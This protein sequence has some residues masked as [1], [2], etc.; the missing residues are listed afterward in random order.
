MHKQLPAMLPLLPN[1]VWR[2]YKGGMTLDQME[3]KDQP[4]DSHFPEDW[5]LST[6][7]AINK[8]REAYVDEG[9]S[10]V[11][12]D[13][14]EYL[15]TDLL[16]QEPQYFLGARHVQQF[17]SHA[18][19]LLKYL[20]SS[21]RLHIQ[22]HPTIAFSQKY[23]N[24]NA[25]KTEGYII[26]GGRENIDPYIYMG[27]QRSPDVATF[28]KAIVD[29]DT[30]TI[31]SYFDKIPVKPGDVFLVPGGI[32]HAIGEG[33]FMV[34]IMEPTDFAV[35][36]EFERG[37]YVLPEEARFM[38]RD[39][40]FAL[41]MFDFNAYDLKQ[42]Q[43]QFFVQPALIQNVDGN[44]QWSLFDQRYTSCFRAERIIVKNQLTL[45]HD[46]MR[47]LIVTYG[48]G[49]VHGG[50]MNLSVCQGQ[51]ILV[52]HHT[53]EIKLVTNSNMEVVNVMP[54]LPSSDLTGQA[55]K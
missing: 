37:G 13:G 23:L 2:T 49:Q 40:D 46:S 11:I 42:L 55:V 21:V 48:E 8:G 24:A 10:R 15:L 47:V 53:G 16:K 28:R 44:E 32:P 43:S 14:R 17:G 30:D 36:I 5:I 4:Q 27:F 54:P 18:G 52:P 41:S 51:R 29:Q 9:I 12:I 3:G 39:V 38:G 6:T 1:R 7:A 20:D 19:F 31:L 35:R 26:L 25:G 34:E 33:V 22:C 45:V 50:D